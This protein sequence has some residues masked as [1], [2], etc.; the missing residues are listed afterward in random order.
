MKLSLSFPLFVCIVTF[1]A[2]TEARVAP[3]RSF[4][5]LRSVVQEIPRGG[6]PFR[7]KQ[8][9]PPPAPPAPVTSTGGTATIPNE[10]FNLVKNI[11][12]KDK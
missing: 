5:S 9:S 10:V 4:S 3:P 12:G 6:G 2:K 11:V 7:K 8:P 1:R